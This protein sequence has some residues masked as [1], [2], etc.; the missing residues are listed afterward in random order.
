VTRRSVALTSA[1]GD[2]PGWIREGLEGLR[3]IACDLDNSDLFI[4]DPTG[5]F[6]ATASFETPLDD[7]SLR[8]ALERIENEVVEVRTIATI[9]RDG[10]PPGFENARRLAGTATLAP[11]KR[12]DYDAPDGAGS[13]YHELRPFSQ[14]DEQM[15]E[16][17]LEVVEPLAGKRL[18]DV[19]CGTGRFT[20]RL[21]EAG[22]T[23][24]G[25]DQ[26]ATM[27]AA[28]RANDPSSAYV[29]GDANDALPAGPWDVITAFYCM[30]YLAPGAFCGRA[31]EEL[32]ADGVLS[33]ATFSHRH[34]AEIEFAKFFPSLAAIDFARFP[35]IPDLVRRFEHGG[36]SNVEARE[37]LVIIEDDPQALLARVERKYLS[38][39]HLLPGAEFH[40]GVE[41]MRAAWRGLDV[42][43][44]TARGTVVS[45]RKT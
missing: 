21:G 6:G 36:F 5:A 24:T 38:S 14:F 26:S 23:V 11:P 2:S 1:A 4:D 12:V 43:R 28:A 10:R 40:A 37:R 18:L 15:L 44:R 20:R 13:Q 34:I 42:V 19:G 25:Y 17:T 27:L 33:V 35:S 3:T 41:A 22:A 45:G 16:A 9:G 39:F 32:S 31:H 30:Q 8:R 7:D 29:R